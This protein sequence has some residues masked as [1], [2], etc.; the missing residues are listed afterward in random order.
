MVARGAM[1]GPDQPVKLHLL[2]I[3]PAAQALEGV[4]MELIDS[5]YP[6]VKGEHD[7]FSDVVELD[8]VRGTN[9]GGPYCTACTM[10]A[11]HV[12]CSRMGHS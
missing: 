3:P 12:E 2:D 4:H 10:S 1:L 9:S 5:A 11:M 7:S 6:L 8:D